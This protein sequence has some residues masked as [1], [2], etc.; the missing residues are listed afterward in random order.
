M[1]KPIPIQLLALY[2]GEEGKAKNWEEED[3]SFLSPVTLSR[4]PVIFVQRGSVTDVSAFDSIFLG[5]YIIIIHTAIS[6]HEQVATEPK[7]KR[8]L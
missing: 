4:G 7:P 8:E 5:V 6:R 2:G 3:R 1:Y